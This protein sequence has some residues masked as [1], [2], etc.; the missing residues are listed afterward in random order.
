[1]QRS[2]RRA[3]KDVGYGD[4]IFQKPS[5]WIFPV[6]DDPKDR[7]RETVSLLRLRPTSILRNLRSPPHGKHKL[8]WL[9]TSSELH[10][11]VLLP[12]CP[13]QAPTPSTN[14]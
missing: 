10:T 11:M 13:P 6:A 14:R 9:S 5:Y 2:S 1:M 12:G 8:A 3:T 7:C 4:N